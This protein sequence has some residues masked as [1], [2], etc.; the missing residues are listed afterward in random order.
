MLV[1]VD[2]VLV[3][4]ASVVSDETFVELIE[5]LVEVTPPPEHC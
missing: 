5:E 3:E 4:L 2:D 1:D